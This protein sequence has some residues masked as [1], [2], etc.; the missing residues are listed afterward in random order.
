MILF[1]FVSSSHADLVD[2][3][4]QEYGYSEDV[5]EYGEDEPSS[6]YVIPPE[7]YAESNIK[8]LYTDSVIVYDSER[9]GILEIRQFSNNVMMY[10]DHAAN[11][12]SVVDQDNEEPVKNGWNVRC[13]K[14]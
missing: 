12:A 6:T 9:D 2:I 8:P 4:D 7:D 5:E 1:V 10:Y 13:N 11:T 14:D 3:G